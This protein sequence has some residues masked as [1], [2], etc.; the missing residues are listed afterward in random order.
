M[1]PEDLFRARHDGCERATIDAIED[2][3]GQLSVA[4]SWSA[5]P[6]GYTYWQEMTRQLRHLIDLLRDGKPLPQVD[7]KFIC[8]LMKRRHKVS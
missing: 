7:E 6:Q 4:F 5:S 8:D 2:I 1:T 3:L